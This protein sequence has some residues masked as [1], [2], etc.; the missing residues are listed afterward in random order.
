MLYLLL[1]ETKTKCFAKVGYTKDRRKGEHNSRLSAYHTHNPSVIIKDFHAG[2]RA[3]E[4]AY[5]NK[6]LS[7]SGSMRTKNEWVEISEDFYNQLLLNGFN[8]I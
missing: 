2:N 4:K 8:A 6:L 5:Y 7:H 1:D 3:T